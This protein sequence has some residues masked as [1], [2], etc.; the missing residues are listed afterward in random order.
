MDLLE[1]GDEGFVVVASVGVGE[2][3]ACAEF[4]EQV[5]YA[6]DGVLRDIS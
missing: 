3:L 1:G 6:D 4:F 2:G 5:V